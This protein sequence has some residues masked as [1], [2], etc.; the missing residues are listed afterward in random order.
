MQIFVT[1][2]GNS[3]TNTI[4]STSSKSTVNEHTCEAES[5]SKAYENPPP[6][7]PSKKVY[8][9]PSMESTSTES[10]SNTSS[11]SGGS[12][13]NYIRRYISARKDT[14]PPDPLN[15]SYDSETLRRDADK[16]RKAYK[17]Y[18]DKL[19]QPVAKRA[20]ADTTLLEA[21]LRQELDN[22]KT[23]LD[24]PMLPIRAPSVSQISTSG[25]SGFTE[26][27]SYSSSAGTTMS[28]SFI[29]DASRERCTS[30]E[31][32][33]D[34]INPLSACV[35]V[36]GARMN[37]EW[38]RPCRRRPVVGASVE[39]SNSMDFVNIHAINSNKPGSGL[40]QRSQSMRYQMRSMPNLVLPANLAQV[41]K[42]KLNY[43]KAYSF[44]HYIDK[45]L[46]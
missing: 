28:N 17:N 9:R 39:T 36:P 31:N 43:D 42:G 7:L 13:G 10:S 34:A 20:P 2:L 15:P 41:R 1:I 3:A 5:I 30:A 19:R 27:G 23:V 18:M 38:N 46:S 24:Q 40:V 22:L 26:G 45:S 37:E 12:G 16:N 33:A 44:S 4:S 35:F 14:L 32:L 21:Q 6:C 11:G 25:S 8:H 29:V